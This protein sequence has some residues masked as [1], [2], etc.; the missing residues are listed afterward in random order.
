MG[1]RCGEGCRGEGVGVAGE[2][3][4]GWG[5]S[6]C[7]QVGE[8]WGRTALCAGSVRASA[9]WS[10]DSLEGRA[11]RSVRNCF[12]KV[13]SAMACICVGVLVCVCVW[14]CRIRLGFVFGGSVFG[15]AFDMAGMFAQSM[16]SFRCSRSWFDTCTLAVEHLAGEV[17]VKLPFVFVTY[18]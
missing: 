14:D 18:M 7:V 6:F 17:R 16:E 9:V 8:R 15:F 5:V 12:A 13:S 2:D 4:L 3:C 11:S 10:E 1:G